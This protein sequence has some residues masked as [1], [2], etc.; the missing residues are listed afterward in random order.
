[1]PGPNT[2]RN[3]INQNDSKNCHSGSYF[4]LRD[5][6]F[7]SALMCGV[8]HWAITV[9]VDNISFLCSFIYFFSFF[10][11]FVCLPVSVKC[12][13]AYSTKVICVLIHGICTLILHLPTW[14]HRIASIMYHMSEPR[15]MTE[16]LGPFSIYD[17][18]S[19]HPTRQGVAYASSPLIRWKLASSEQEPGQWPSIVFYLFK[20]IS[21]YQISVERII[22][23]DA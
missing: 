13:F 1:M 8:V 14:M 7:F 18:A 12:T 3:A 10:F 5:V 6:Y 4:I 22:T 11:S 21:V 16:Y 23:A 19:S 17:S 2:E 9:R 20:C 15:G